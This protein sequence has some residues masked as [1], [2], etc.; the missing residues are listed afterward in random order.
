MLN[1]ND[2]SNAKAFVAPPRVQSPEMK[3]IMPTSSDRVTSP[4]L[5]ALSSATS[6]PNASQNASEWAK[7][8]PAY[9]SSPN[10]LINLGESPPTQPSSYEDRLANFGWTTKEQR[11]IPNAHP[12]SAS[13]PANRRRPLSYQMDGNF[14]NGLNG[15]NEHLSQA[16]AY[17]NR[18]SSMYSQYSQNAR[19]GPHPPLPHQVQP[20]FYGAPDANLML[21]PPQPG[22]V[23]GENGYHC[24]LDILSSPDVQRNTDNA[25]VT[26]YQ[27][28]L[29]VFTVT[30]RG[31]S[32]VH[33]LD[34][35]RGGVY[36]AKVLPWTLKVASAREFPLIAVVVHGPTWTSS[37]ASSVEYDRPPS[38]ST[39]FRQAESVRSSPKLGHSV[40]ENDTTLVEYYQT[41]VEV[42]SLKTKKHITTLLSLPKTH[43]TIPTTSPSF[44]A[45]P[46]VGSL[47]IRADCPNIVVTSGATGET[48]IFHHIGLEDSARPR[49]KCI[50]KVWTTVQQGLSIDSNDLNGP[51][52]G[53]WH[54][55][56]SPSVQQH[57]KASILSL[58]GRW[59][60]YCPSLPSSQISLR[61]AVQ[62]VSSTTKVPGLNAYAP[63]QLPAQN[64][65][66]ETLEAQSMLKQFAQTATQEFIKGASYMGKQGAQYWNNYWNKS[67]AA[68]PVV[69]ANLYRPHPNVTQQFPP[70]HGVT[71]Q[72]APINKN[73]GL[74]SILDLESLA[75]QNS[76]TG[77]SPHPIATFKLPHGCSFLS[78]APSGLA[79]FT[80]SSKGDMQCIWDLMRLQYAKSSVLKETSQSNGPNTTHVR[81]IAQFSRM[82]IARIVDVVW[83]S[84]HGER[85]AVVTEPGTVHILDLPASAFTWPP[86]RRKLA[87]AK[88]QEPNM[89]ITITSTAI[90]AAGVA[91]NAVSSLFT[92][93]RGGRRRRSSAGIAS[94]AAA[95]VT[96]QAGHGTRALAAGISRSVGAATGKMNELRKASRANLHLPKSSTV[97]TPGCVRLISGKRNDSIILVGGGIVRLYTVKSRQ[98]DRPADKQKA[99]RGAQYVEFRLPSLPD[100]K[101]APEMVRDLNQEED[102][103]FGERDAEAPR[104]KLTQNHGMIRS[105]GTESSIPQAEIESNAPYQPFHTDRRVGLHVY[106]YEKT[107]L[108]SPSVSALL[109]PPSIPDTASSET[110]CTGAWAFGGPINTIRL[111]IG[112]SSSAKGD[113]D[114]PSVHRALPS[115]AIE[116][117]MRKADSREDTEQIVI[118]TRRRKGASQDEEGFFEDDCEVLDFAD[119]RV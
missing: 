20:H 74:I 71:S 58:N 26:G 115:S 93:A 73:P 117:I 28:G 62:G 52:D 44:K 55:N 103:D 84:P 102:L 87:G 47:T 76:S 89:D 17:S 30:K 36:N 41:T 108:P 15:L 118:T 99:S 57:Y 23:P 88:P 18:R 70:T 78:F 110:L 96:S 13:P 85:A 65:Q 79:L 90:S 29:N 75:H 40:G 98:A 112:T 3:P 94:T 39:S 111:D 80:A 104:Q 51:V 95:S 24:G 9:S 50:G 97:P 42:Y 2:D 19:Y 63:P 101:F 107:L 109:S 12:P 60:A 22:I 45:P 27:G 69:G 37:V 59:L 68:T 21:S 49:F 11:G 33:F 31:L 64:C 83:T 82:T 5:E 54:S 106:F 8:V 10:N 14:P 53:D 66:V 81:E 43:L 6:I 32:K 72:S 119:Q 7:N 114:S 1:A 4:V 16:A 86:P 116:R 105:S 91:S 113:I 77:A 25:I 61:A 38:E 46:P 67:S 48:W 35:L 100:L 34:R 92:A 56:E